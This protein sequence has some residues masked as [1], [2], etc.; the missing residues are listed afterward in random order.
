MPNWVR[1]KLFI[2]G[3]SDKVKQ[4][5]LDISSDN[6]HICFEKILPRPKDIGD[7]WYDWSIDNWGTKWDVSESYEDEN[8]F[9]CF[10]TAW[11]TPASLILHLSDKYTDLSFEVLYA[12]EDLG[13]NCGRYVF[14]NGDE[15]E[16]EPYDI[17]EAC[18]IWGYDMSEI[19][20]DLYRDEQIDKLI[21]DEE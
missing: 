19:Y 9:I 4:C 18:D 15:L 14:K 1:N 6:E 2:H 8:G 13:S 3:D 11:S 10:D 21:G 17:K 16:F 5:T 12:D 7:D 20:P